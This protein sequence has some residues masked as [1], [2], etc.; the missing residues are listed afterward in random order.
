MFYVYLLVCFMILLYFG[1]KT[2]L[3]LPCIVFLLYSVDAV[4]SFIVR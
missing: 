4:L 2:Y 1:L 3:I